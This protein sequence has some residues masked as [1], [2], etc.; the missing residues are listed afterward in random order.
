MSQPES[1]ARSATYKDWVITLK[2]RLRSLQLKAVVT[3]NAALLEFYWQ[4]GAEIAEK[5]KIRRWGDGFLQQ[6]SQDLRAEFPDLKG[7]SKRNLEQIRRWYL[8]Y[9]EQNAIAQQAVSQLTQIPWGHNIKIVSK[10]KTHAEAL[11]YVNK[12]IEQG[13]SRNVLV[14]QI[15]SQLWQREG[16]AVANFATTLPAP[17]S[18]NPLVFRNISLCVSY[19]M[20]FSLA[21][22]LLSS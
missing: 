21:C 7:F 12:T 20:R 13:W 9:T 11:Y 2:T 22:R 10:C 16:K 6:L 14:H 19:P 17:Q 1:L 4:L 8:F 15:E 18:A 5:Q 3:V